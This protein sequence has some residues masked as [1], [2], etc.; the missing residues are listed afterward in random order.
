MSKLLPTIDEF[1][2]SKIKEPFFEDLYESFK[3]RIIERISQINKFEDSTHRACAFIAYVEDDDE[4]AKICLKRLKN[5]LEETVYDDKKNMLKG[6]ITYTLL[7]SASHIY[8]LCKNFPSWQEEKHYISNKILLMANFVY[9]N[10]GSEQNTN[11]L[12]NWQALRYA[13]AGIGFIAN[14]EPDVDRDVKLYACYMKSK[15]YIQSAFN[16]GFGAPEGHGYTRYAWSGLGRF[17]IALENYNGKLI[18][19]A[20]DF[21]VEYQFMWSLTSLVSQDYRYE[22]KNFKGSVPSF[23]DDTFNVN[24]VAFLAFAYYYLDDSHKPGLQRIVD[25][26]IDFENNRIFMSRTD[27]FI[28]FLLYYDNNII[29]ESPFKNKEWC[30]VFKETKGSGYTTF[31]NTFKDENDIVCQTHSKLILHSGHNEPDN[32]GFRILG[33]NTNWIIGGGW[34]QQKDQNNIPY[35]IRSSSTVFPGGY[36][37]PNEP[38][39]H[40]PWNNSGKL[41]KSEVLGDTSKEGYAITFMCPNN[42]DTQYFTRRVITKFNVANCSASFIIADT[43]LNG[44]YWQLCTQQEH[45]VTHGNNYF[46]ITDPSTG[47]SMKGHVLSLHNDSYNITTGVRQRGSPYLSKFSEKRTLGIKYVIV[48]NTKP[49]PGFDKSMPREDIDKLFYSDTTNWIPKSEYNGD[50]L[51]VLT[52]CDRNQQ[53]PTV[54]LSGNDIRNEVTVS[55][56]NYKTLIRNN[57]ITMGIV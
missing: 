16:G 40:K 31:R 5:I 14:D 48:E 23:V 51:V 12:S 38:K 46:L 29:P 36:G 25:Q 30:E 56:G 4:L 45:E 54:S 17:G 18:D 8:D 10:G 52:L 35:F 50:F 1:I 24:D 53:H 34:Y 32:G 22:G 41:I 3:L 7:I 49:V 9:L 55:V 19:E 15:K 11:T 20:D 26:F 39:L 13:S 43:T 27:G 2:N 37:G 28:Y 57:D 44:R 42:Y 21:D 47:A 6:L 33:L